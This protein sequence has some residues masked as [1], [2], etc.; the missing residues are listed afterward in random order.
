MDGVGELGGTTVRRIDRERVRGAME[1][2]ES[3]VLKRWGVLG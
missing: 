3:D 2:L 1:G